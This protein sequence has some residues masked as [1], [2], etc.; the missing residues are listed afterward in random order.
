[1]GP[2][3]GGKGARGKP[4]SLA[5]T[6]QGLAIAKDRSLLGIGIGLLTRGTVDRGTRPGR[7]RR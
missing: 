3:P 1:M 7:R 5:P 4:G 6:E 2:L